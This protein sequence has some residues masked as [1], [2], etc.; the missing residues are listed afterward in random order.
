MYFFSENK[1]GAKQ[2]KSSFKRKSR[3]HSGIAPVL[4]LSHGSAQSIPRLSLVEEMINQNNGAS[5]FTLYQETTDD[6]AYQLQNEPINEVIAD[7]KADIPVQGWDPLDCSNNMEVLNN[8]A[9][10]N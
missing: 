5:G 4:V 1:M 6:V 3:S 7:S 8:G 9:K 2:S 10:V